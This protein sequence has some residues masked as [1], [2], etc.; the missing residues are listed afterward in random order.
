MDLS[1]KKERLKEIDVVRGITILLVVC[2]HVGL[3]TDIN[4][5][6]T[7]FRMPLFFIVTGYLFSSS[8]YIYDFNKFFKKRATSLL[9]PYFSACILFLLLSVPLNYVR[10]LDVDLGGSITGILYGNGDGLT[11]IFATPLWFL[12]CLFCTQ[13]LFCILYRITHKYSLVVQLLSFMSIGVVGY[14]TSKSIHLPWGFDIALVALPL[15]FLGYKAKEYKFL[16]NLK[17]TFVPIVIVFMVFISSCYLNSPVDMNNRAYLNIVLFYVTGISGSI[18]VIYIAKMLSEIYLPTKLLT[19]MGRES[20]SILIFHSHSALF[21]HLLLVEL[22][23]IET[24]FNWVAI[25]IGGIVISLLI[26]RA[27]K[28]IPALNFLFNGIKNE[29][30]RYYPKTTTQ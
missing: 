1:V 15:F 13:I 24:G 29:N 4:N 23:G 30:I 2:S 18:L 5:I 3:P 14:F 26:N 20:L 16:R 17:I 22:L 8:K 28:R 21:M 6:L 9:L 7:T 19:V 25:A 11:H 10:G 12:V 27:I